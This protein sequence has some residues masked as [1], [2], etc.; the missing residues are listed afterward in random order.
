VRL[1]WVGTAAGLA[2]VAGALAAASVVLRPHRPTPPA[3]FQGTTE[4][5]AVPLAGGKPRIVLRLPGQ[6]GLPRTTAD[7]KALL[8]QRPQPLRTD[9]YRV[10]LDGARRTWVRR[11]P[12]F[13]PSVSSARTADGRYL[14]HLGRLPV[15][16]VRDTRTGRERT[17]LR[18]PY[19]DPA[20]SP[21][22]KTVYVLRLKAAVSI[23]K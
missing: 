15:V 10:P 4:V 2:V 9:L 5:Y 12:Y 3:T 20:L 7:G 11:L 19:F 8:L 1:L 22:G 13:G 16:L 14:V 17:L 18:G 21:D 23:P 6:W